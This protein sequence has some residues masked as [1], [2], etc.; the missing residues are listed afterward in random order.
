MKRGLLSIM[1]LGML[2]QAS[3]AEEPILKD[4]KTRDSYSL[5]YEFGENLR[6]QGLDMNVDTLLTAVR[7]AL[8]GKKPA[9]TPEEIRDTMQQLR[10]KMLTKQEQRTRESAIKTA[11]E[12]RAF[13][14][15]NKLKEGVTTLPSGLQYKVLRDGNGPSPQATDAVKVHYRG[16]LVNG[17]E[18]DSSY[19]RD[20]PT[21]VNVNGVIRGW[22]EA[23]QMMK[24]GSKWQL[25]VPAELAYGKRQFGR[26]PPNSMLI[27]E[28]ELLSIEHKSDIG[29][30]EPAHGND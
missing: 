28:V 24:T 11:E 8:E 18:F 13:L 26:I 5:G 27:F 12:G 20:E 9:L 29:V 3:W 30:A 2:I 17:A 6:N 23:L 25:F 19:R 14:T 10:K 7:E 16:T 1:I 15:A 21:T 22:T 4:Q